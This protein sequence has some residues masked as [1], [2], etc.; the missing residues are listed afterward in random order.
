M[1]MSQLGSIGPV[2]RLAIGGGGIGQ[3]WGATTRLEALHTLQLAIE[4]G[5]NLI[6]LAPA[7]GRG[8][9]E[10]VVAEAFRGELPDHV[11][12]TTKCQL[13]N[14]A[15]ADV[16]AILRRS[17]TRSL[18]TLELERVDI[19]ILHS[20]IIP[21]GFRLNVPESVQVK[22]ATQWSTYTE[23][24]IPAFEKF[25]K[26]GL[27]EHWGITGIGLPSSIIDAMQ[28]PVKPAVVQC[29]TNLL[30]S[31]GAMRCFDEDPQPRNIIQIAKS[32][33]I[34]VLGVRAVQAGALTHEFDRDLPEDHPDRTDFD[35][36]VDFRQLA[37]DMGTDPAILAHQYALSIPHVD[38][39]ILGVKNRDELKQCLEA[40]R[41]SPLPSAV[42]RKID[43][44]VP[45]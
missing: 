41:K 2:S 3:V 13:G 36:A 18:T 27:I 45:W 23:S 12:V 30:D 11:R 35:R 43:D 33:N 34:G 17:L 15:A 26:E 32:L 38:S 29:I 5:I 19:F 16:E 24:V 4:S 10:R 1:K 44:C 28:F 31:P 42:I 6:D 22:M 25:C 21:D 8:E 14:P 37:E 39:V 20:N 40:E 7:Y 9:A